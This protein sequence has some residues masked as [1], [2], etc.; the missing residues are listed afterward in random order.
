MCIT[1][2]SLSLWRTHVCARARTYMHM[3]A[4]ADKDTDTDIHAPTRKHKHMRARVWPFLMD[5]RNSSLTNGFAK[6]WAYHPD[7]RNLQ[8]SWRIFGDVSVTIAPWRRVRTWKFWA[9]HSSPVRFRPKP[10]H[11]KSLWIWANRPLSKGSKLLF[12]VTKANIIKSDGCVQ[13]PWLTFIYF[14]ARC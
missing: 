13:P 6:V 2:I 12:P 8:G 9:I 10:C 1:Y 7:A 5:E 4:H 11:L 14:L 3:H